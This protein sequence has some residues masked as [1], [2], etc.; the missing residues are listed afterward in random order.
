MCGFPVTMKFNIAIYKDTVPW[1][2][3]YLHSHKLNFDLLRAGNS[4]PQL[5]VSND[6]VWEPLNYALS[7]DVL[8]CQDSNMIQGIFTGIFVDSQI[9]V[10]AVKTPFFKLCSRSS[11]P[12]LHLLQ[13]WRPQFSKILDFQPKTC[14]IFQISPLLKPIFARIS[15]LYLKNFFKIARLF[16]PYFCLKSVL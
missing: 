5:K 7:Y 16:S 12:Q 4:Y 15:T 10:C 13:F 14:Q 2:P 6:V 3:I 11:D 9:L 1:P 8:L